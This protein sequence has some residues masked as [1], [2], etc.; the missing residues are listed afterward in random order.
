MPRKIRQIKADLR[1]AEFV[2]LPGR[3]KGD[4]TMYQHPDVADAI[5]GLDG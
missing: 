4:H 5:V 2:L 3:G 1:R